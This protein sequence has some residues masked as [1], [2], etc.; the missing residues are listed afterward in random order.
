MRPGARGASRARAERPWGEQVADLQPLVH[1]KVDLKSSLQ[2]ALGAITAA[3]P[4]PRKPR[5]LQARS[6]GPLRAAHRRPDAP[7]PPPAL[8]RGLV[9]SFFVFG[10]SRS[11]PP[12]PVLTGHV[13]SV[14]PY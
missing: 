10:T 2:V 4:P 9:P 11:P 3:P 12:L 13:S 1:A 14:S 6:G 7:P 8:Q 5:A